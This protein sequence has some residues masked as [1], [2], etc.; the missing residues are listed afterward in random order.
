MDYDIAIR[1][2]VVTAI[3][4]SIMKIFGNMGILITFA[5]IGIFLTVLYLFQNKL[6]YMPGKKYCK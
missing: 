3:A 4:V 1:V 2:I 5:L 6:L